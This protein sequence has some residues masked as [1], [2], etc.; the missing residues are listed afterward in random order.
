MCARKLLAKKI[1]IS[2]ALVACAILHL[3]AQNI[4]FKRQEVEA[5]AADVSEDVRKHYY[6]PKLHDTDWEGK[7]RETQRKIET[8]NS[9]NQAFA[10]VAAMLENLDDS[11]T[12]LIPPPRSF[13]LDYGWRIQ[14]IGDRCLVTH[15]RPETDAATKVHPG[16]EVLTVNDYKP[17]RANMWGIGYLLN[18]IRP[19]SKLEVTVRSPQGEVR[20]IELIPKVFPGQLMRASTGDWRM[21]EELAHKESEPRL[22]S[23]SDDVLLAR[24]PKFWLDDNDVDKLIAEARKHKSVI[25][26]LRG[27]SKGTNESVKV[28]VSRLFDHEVKIAD[29]VYRN[30]D[31]PMFAKPDRHIFSGKLLVL[32]DSWS[33]SAAEIFARVIQLEKRG[34]VLG[35]HTFGMVMKA[36]VYA[37]RSAAGF[38]GTSV[39]VA[40]VI[41]PDGELLEHVGITPDETVLP[42]ADDLARD[43]DP[44]LAHAAEMVG[45]KL[46]AEDAARLHP[47][48]WETPYSVVGLGNWF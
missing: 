24:I 22:I 7:L 16:D 35:D 21:V 2:G 1:G 31:A 47:Y 44:L 18:V 48:Q 39:S 46:T 30:G 19:Q 27:N 20:Q 5:I 12:F 15:V 4:G 28:L 36:E 40:E 26:D 8:A 43:R 6:D 37:H 38:F 9:S 17:T 11:Q 32:V 41:M 45:V 33:L 29:L 42:T 13:S 34:I 25:L 3:L 23:L 14:T 10:D